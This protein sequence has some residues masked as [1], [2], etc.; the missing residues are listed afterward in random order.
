MALDQIRLGTPPSGQDGDDARTAFSR[1]NANFKSMD[2][3]GLTGSMARTVT[4]LN[5]AIQPGWYAALSGTAG[6]LPPGITYPVVFVG[7]HNAGFIVQQATDVISGKVASRAYNAN[8]SGSWGNWVVG[9][10]SAELG[11]AAY[12]TL[13]TSKTD[14]TVGRALKVN[15]FGWGGYVETVS[16]ESTVIN[17]VTASGFYYVT[18]TAGA[19]SLPA[20]SSNGYLQVV[21][22]STAY[23]IQTYTQVDLATKWERCRFNGTWGA[24]VRSY[25]GNNA[26]GAVAGVVGSSAIIETGSNANGTYVRLADGTQFCF[27]VAGLVNILTPNAAASV[28]FTLPAAFANSYQV[29]ANIYSVNV[30]NEFY[31]YSRTS[32]LTGTTFRIVHCW[33]VVQTYG[34][35]YFAIGRWK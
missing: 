19:G 10:T 21:A 7:L 26:V 22:H 34:Y 1:I 23:V 28:D 35:Q 24:W 15:D 8:G 6:H 29:F 2:D 3:W 5:D 12:A 25:N 27:G 13:T 17:N 33:S 14:S 4:D 32:T 11:S 9:V 20:G 30:S 16:I 18:T 31:G